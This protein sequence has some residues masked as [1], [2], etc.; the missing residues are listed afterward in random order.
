MVEKLKEII[1]EKLG[2]EIEEIKEESRFREELKA[3]SLDLFELVMAIEEEFG[4]SIPSEDLEKL[5]TVG[6]VIS[7]MKQQGIEE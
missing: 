2:V 6:D 1:A 5:V 7:Y 4:N 3:N